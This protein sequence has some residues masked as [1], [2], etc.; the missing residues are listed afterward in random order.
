MRPDR[1]PSSAITLLAILLGS[2]SPTVEESRAEPPAQDGW[3]FSFSDR[4]RDSKSLID[5]RSLNEP[6][7]GQSGFVRLS[8]DGNDFT[9]GDGTPVRFWAIGSE[10][11]RT[12]SPD[13]LRR[14]VRFLARMGVNMVRLHAQICPPGPNAKVTDVNEKEID[15]LWRFVAEAKKQGIYVTISPYWANITDAS[16]WGI[17]GHNAPGNLNGLLFF[18]ETLQ[19]GYQAWA[20]ALFARPNPYTNIPLAKDPAVAII[21]VQNEDSLLFWTSQLMPPAQKARLGQKFG[22]WLLEKYGSLGAWTTAWAGASHKDDD[23]ASGKVGL[24]DVYAM[25]IPQPGPSGRRAADQVA[26]YATTQKEFYA[27]I[28]RYYRDQLGC[29]QL[30]NASNWKT[31]NQTTLDDAERWSYSSTDVIA[32]NR[33]YNGGAHL[34]GNAGWRIDPGDKFSQRSALLNPRELPVNLKQVV[35]HPMIVT[36][37]NWVTPLAFQSEGPFLVAVYES[38]TGV[39]AFYWFTADSVDYKTNPFF[40]YQQVNGQQPLLKWSASIPPI[41]GSF[42][43]D[44]LLFRRGYVKKGEP[45]VHEERSLPSLWDRETPLIAEDPSFD[46]NRDRARPVAGRPGERATAVDPLAFLVGPVE[47]KYEGD[48]S[49]SRVVDLA[50]FIDH[51]KKLVRS[52]TGEVALDYN[53]G[54]CTVD[55]PKAQGACGFLAQAGLIRLGDLSIRSANSYA[56]V[57]AVSLDDLP[58]ATS[59]SILIQVA[60]AARPTGWATKP[61]EFKEG[62]R[63]IRGLEVV[64]TGKPPWRVADAEFGLSL[65]NPGLTKATRLDPGGFPAENVPL[66]KVKTGVTFTPPTDTMYLILE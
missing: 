24:L 45:V 32:V 8:A 52:I 62:D 21:Q 41:L 64:S 39:D 35:G 23:L 38:L 54:L 46:P 42:P 31:A 59:K 49:K 1:P 63:T 29:G 44:A 18:D 9:L 25:T 66:T 15:G 2:C 19:K 37:S 34:G 3:A 50:R 58:L 17:E 27:G 5:L 4:E 51:D 13:E 53:V 60:T 47:V 22:R 57:L 65:R 36:E 6:V 12:G 7:A 30:I 10:L 33:Y 28:A 16:K 48:P 40:P 61:A 56:T 55:A 26:F 43:A 11:F 14:H 20:S